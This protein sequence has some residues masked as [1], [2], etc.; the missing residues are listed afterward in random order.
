MKT[1]KGR[2]GMGQKEGREF[3]VK[4]RELGKRVEG[5]DKIKYWTLKG[6]Y[7]VS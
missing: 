3:W 4:L 6:Q 1:L 5:G 2:G 7:S